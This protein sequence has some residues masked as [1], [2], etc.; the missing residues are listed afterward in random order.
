[1]PEPRHANAASTQTAQTRK[2]PISEG[3]PLRVRFVR[4]NRRVIEVRIRD[5]DA[6]DGLRQQHVLRVDEV[7]ARVLRE[8]ELL[9]ERDRVERAGE[10][11]VAAEDAAAEVDLVDPCVALAGGDPV[12]GGVLRRHDAD[13]IGGAGSRAEGAADALLEPVL[14][15]PEPVA[16]A[17]AR[18][19]GPLVLRVLLRDRLLEDLLQRDAEA[20][21]GPDRRAPRHRAPSRA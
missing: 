7:V 2:S 19:D 3:T 15:A 20:L 6:L 17:E 4:R 14:E 12:V 21:E 1:M 13:A 9:L 10:L 11:A 5:R 18:V 16:P 8:L